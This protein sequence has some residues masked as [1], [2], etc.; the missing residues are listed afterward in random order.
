MTKVVFLLQFFSPI[1][2]DRVLIEYGPSGRPTGEA[3]AYF[4][5][6]QDAVAAMS[7]DREYISKLY[8]IVN[9]C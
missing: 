5:T 3:E 8:E 7:K 9:L 6:H 4:T 2:P 1:R